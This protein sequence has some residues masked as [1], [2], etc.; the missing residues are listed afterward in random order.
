[1]FKN[2]TK[3]SRCYSLKL[4]RKTRENFQFWWSLHLDKAIAREDCGGFFLFEILNEKLGLKFSPTLMLKLES[5][6]QVTQ[7]HGLEPN[8]YFFPLGSILYLLVYKFTFNSLKITP[9]NYPWLIHGSKTEIKKKVR[10]NFSCNHSVPERKFY[11]KRS[12]SRKFLPRNK[13]NL[14]FSSKMGGCLIHGIDLYM[15]KYLSIAGLTL[16]VCHCYS[17][18]HQWVVRDVVGWSF[19]FRRNRGLQEVRPFLCDNI[20]VVPLYC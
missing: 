7:V 4:K 20:T 18:M 6:T 8:Y 11:D 1:M 17:F 3:S 5:W 13:K 2:H 16:A 19:L 15:G 14:L 12:F 10:I 9:K